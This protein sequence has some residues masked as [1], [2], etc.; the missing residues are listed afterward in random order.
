V[1]GVAGLIFLGWR[2]LKIIKRSQD[3]D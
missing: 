3:L 1:L 2:L